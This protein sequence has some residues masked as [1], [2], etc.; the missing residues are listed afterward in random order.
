MGA[1]LKNKSKKTCSFCRRAGIDAALEW[2]CNLFF[3]GGPTIENRIELKIQNTKKRFL[4]GVGA[5]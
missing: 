3:A 5:K 2:E 1:A 4:G